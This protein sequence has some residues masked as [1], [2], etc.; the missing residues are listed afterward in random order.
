MRRP[1]RARDAFQA[2]VQR[3]LAGIPARF[4]PYLDNVTVEVRSR[5]S[6]EIVRE[7][8]LA[9][10]ET[11]YGYYSG[12][13]LTSRTPDEP[14]LYPDRILIFQEPLEEDF[15]DDADE[16]VRQIRV[17]VLHEIGHH[18]GLEDEDMEHLEE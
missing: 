1:R 10:D 3:A 5:P 17:T 11:L 4:R 9:E 12:T 7:M 13:P 8:G 14:P 15:G 18:F 2:L 6:P 16:I